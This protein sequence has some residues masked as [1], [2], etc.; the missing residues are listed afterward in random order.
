[1]LKHQHYLNFLMFLAYS[2]V[3]QTLSLPWCRR[4]DVMTL[5]SKFL[6]AC[7]HVL[8]VRH[9]YDPFHDV[10]MCLARSG[11]QSNAKE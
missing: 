6:F 9:Y 11:R 10:T 1:M 8:S 2:L 5:S 4:L 7:S 3:M